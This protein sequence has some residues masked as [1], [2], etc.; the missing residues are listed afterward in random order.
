MDKQ[1]LLADQERALAR[2]GEALAEPP[3]SDNTNAG[4]IQFFEF[5]FELEALAALLRG[6]RGA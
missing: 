2:L 5:A 6:L 1:R 3:A 4:C